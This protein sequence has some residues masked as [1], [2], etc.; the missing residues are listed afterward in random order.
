MKRIYLTVVI[1]T[2]SYYGFSQIDS[3]RGYDYLAEFGDTSML[4]TDIFCSNYDDDPWPA[5][6]TYRTERAFHYS[7]DYR[8]EET[9]HMITV[10]RSI[11]AIQY[12]EIYIYDVFQKLEYYI[13]KTDDTEMV[14]HFLNNEAITLRSIGIDK[15]LDNY[16]IN[17]DETYFMSDEIIVRSNIELDICEKMTGIPNYSKELQIVR[18]RYKETN[19]NANLKL[20]VKDDAKAYYNGNELVKIV[21]KSDITKEYYIENKKL[22]FAFYTANSDTP[23]QRLYCSSNGYPFKMVYGDENFAKNDEKFWNYS[24][25]I[26]DDFMNTISIFE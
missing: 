14:L 5:V 3:R 8:C 12:S 13:Y 15:L 1:I 7:D 26:L 22:Y 23:E 6:G 20:V 9:L 10:H 2:I 19:A 16:F 4:Y 11:A 24:E 21:V 17:E 18:D 25:L